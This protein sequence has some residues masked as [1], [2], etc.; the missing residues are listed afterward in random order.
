MR[1]LSSLESE[2]GLSLESERG[3]SLESGR[4]VESRK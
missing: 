4:G 2:R 3:W 1:G